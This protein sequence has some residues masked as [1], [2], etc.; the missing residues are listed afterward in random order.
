MIQFHFNE[1][2][3]SYKIFH[4]QIK[5]AASQQLKRAK[6]IDS[7]NEDEAQGGETEENEGAQKPDD[8][9]ESSDEGVRN[10]DGAG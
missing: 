5:G 2:N 6:I 4:L 8:G 10:D 7:D 9:G 3:V 1:H